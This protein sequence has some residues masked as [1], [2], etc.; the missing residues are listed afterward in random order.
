MN[1]IKYVAFV[2]GMI[3]IMVSCTN[4]NSKSDTWTE[5]QEMQW[6]KNCLRMLE[7]NDVFKGSAEDVCDC[8]FEKTSEKYTPAEVTNLTEDQE[9]EIWEECDY[10]W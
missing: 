4:Y 1:K 7:E 3:F 2:V 6:K 9:R 8:M 10:N 5:K